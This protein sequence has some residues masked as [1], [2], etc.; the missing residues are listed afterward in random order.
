MEHES[1]KKKFRIDGWS[2]IKLFY[3]MIWNGDKDF[4]PAKI[5]LYMFILNQGNRASWPE[6]IDLPVDTG[7]QGACIASKT[8]YYQSLKE[9]V[10]FQLIQYR[11]GISDKLTP[12]IKILDLRVSNIG[13][14]AMTKQTTD[15]VSL[16]DMN[17]TRP[18]S[19]AMETIMLTP[20]KLGKYV[21]TKDD[22]RECLGESWINETGMKYNFDRDKFGQFVNDRILA[23]T[24]AGDWNYPVERIREFCIKDYQKSINHKPNN[25]TCVSD[26]VLQMCKR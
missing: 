13:T 8:T 10:N 26:D 1:T 11:K 2:Q 12:K 7:M 16:D 14:H 17:K 21:I 24:A 25:N 9:L 23:M 5:S 4:T 20:K 19:T 15:E 22:L 6:W 3:E 18:S